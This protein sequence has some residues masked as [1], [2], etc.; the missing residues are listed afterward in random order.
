MDVLKVDAEGYE[1]RIIEGARGALGSG[2]I[3][4]IYIEFNDY[5]LRKLGSS[6]AGLY[7]SLLALGFADRHGPFEFP[8]G[9]VISRF[10][11]RHG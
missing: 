8:A 3:R 1:P 2:A 11:S 6:P 4:N 10:L 5:Y 7:E 9:C